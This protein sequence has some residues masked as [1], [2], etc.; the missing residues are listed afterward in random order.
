MSRAQA[1]AA[2]DD[3]AWIIAHNERLADSYAA[4]GVT[5]AVRFRERVES[6]LLHSA[7]TVASNSTNA[8]IAAT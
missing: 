4:K 2:A 6:A 1:S 5:Q 3:I 8:A 7:H